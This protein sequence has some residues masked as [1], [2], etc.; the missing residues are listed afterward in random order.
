M[1]N[2]INT[3]PLISI[4]MSVF[5]GEKYLEDAI[6]SILNQTYKNWEFVIINDGSTDL[7][8]SIVQ[9]YQNDHRIKYF[10]HKNIGLAKSLNRGIQL[11][12]GEYIARLDSDDRAFPERLQK[13]VDFFISNP[14]VVLLGSAYLQLD[15][16]A[17]M[18]LSIINPPQDNLG[19]RKKLK[20]GH[21]VFHHS[22]VMFKRQIDGET[23]FY[24][25]ISKISQYAEDVRLWI[26]LCSK[27][28]VSVLPDVLCCVLKST[29]QSL[30]SGRS[31]LKRLKLQFQL[32]QIAR[33][34]LNGNF[35]DLIISLFDLLKGFFF[36]FLKNLIIN[37]KFLISFYTSARY[38]RLKK[39]KFD[40]KL[41]KLWSSNY[42]ANLKIRI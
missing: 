11:A 19:C 27:G 17:G 29:P 18:A 33:S 4:V 39:E 25:D 28:R 40:P 42:E 9:S 34:E 24:D 22:S 35:Y 8:E 23:I 32:S 30:S 6:Q 21:S 16:S 31:P 15:A 14:D 37:N 36:V 20:F 26:T 10:Y 38:S 41:V 1:N 13:Q 2:K 3:Q 7:T 12:R 5:N